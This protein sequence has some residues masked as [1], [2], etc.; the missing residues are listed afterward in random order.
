MA[1]CC[2][3]NFGISNNI[4]SL[5]AYWLD[6]VSTV[7]IKTLFIQ[8]I[9]G[10]FTHCHLYSGYSISIIVRN[11]IMRVAEYIKKKIPA[12]R[13]IVLN[14]MINELMMHDRIVEEYVRNVFR[15]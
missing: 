5:L 12:A 3:S 15:F 13:I 11:H 9:H 8:I 6:H 4:L 10:G 14:D 1:H 2:N 7:Y